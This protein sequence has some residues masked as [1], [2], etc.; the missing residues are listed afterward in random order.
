MVLEKRLQQVLA[1]LNPDLPIEA[2]DD[3]YQ[4]TLDALCDTLLPK[5]LSGE[6]RVK[7]AEKFV[8]AET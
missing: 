5:V 4:V 3:P 6:I 1:R 7:G 8:E 2:L